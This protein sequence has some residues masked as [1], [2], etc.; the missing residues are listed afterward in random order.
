M[1]S[2]M[3]PN[4]L[5]TN[6]ERASEYYLLQ[7]VN[8]MMIMMV[9]LMLMIEQKQTKKTN[10]KIVSLLTFVFLRS[11]CCCQTSQYETITKFFPNCVSYKFG[12]TKTGPHLFAL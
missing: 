3:I 1:I 4:E 12:P 6:D 7:L 9:V 5:T 11:R 8:K 2:Q 10:G